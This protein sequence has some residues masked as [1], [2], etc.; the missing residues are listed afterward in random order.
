MRILRRHAERNPVYLRP[1][2]NCP[3]TIV[4]NGTVTFGSFSGVTGKLDIRGISNSFSGLPAPAL[5][6]NLR[7]K[8]R[9]SYVFSI[10]KYIGIVEFFDDKAFGLAEVVFWN[11]ETGQ[12]L[13]YHTFMGPRRR[14][15]PTDT[16]EAACTSFG[17]T[18]YI[19]I[20]WSRRHKRISLSFTVRGDRF[21]P[22]AKGKFCAPFGSEQNEEMLSVSP[23]PTIHRCSATWL[24]PMEITGGIGTAKHRRDITELPQNRG[25]A[26]MLANRTY[27]KIRS[28]K[29]SMFGFAESDGRKII[30]TFS[31]SS[32]DAVDADA[33]N[34]NLLSV[35]GVITAMPPVYITH[36][37]GLAKKWI[38]Q[39]T[40]NMVDLSFQP[41]SCTN[42]T[43]N[44]IFMKNAYTTIYGTFDG[45]LLSKDGDKI[46]L[47]NC[48]GIVK[49]NMFRL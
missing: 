4:T 2:T 29:S 20:A 30:F 33:Y 46:I 43:L 44:L 13:A 28:E 16:A 31:N 36:P 47:K 23:A 5:V 32:Q 24:V 40:E 10:D 21:R 41:A 48:P 1:L 42:R 7:I 14:F 8:S 34:D 12:K 49:K 18:R 9:I 6:S 27:L 26:I 39:D 37:L 11:K 38:C 45:A 15:V 19:K 35:N 3:E 17:K 22:A 25:L